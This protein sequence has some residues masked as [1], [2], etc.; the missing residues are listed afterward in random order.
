MNINKHNQICGCP[1]S[2]VKPNAT[3]QYSNKYNTD[4]TDFSKVVLLHSIIRG[5]WKEGQID[6]QCTTA[7]R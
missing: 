3:K 2:S 4:L 7:G 6:K 1:K 5:K